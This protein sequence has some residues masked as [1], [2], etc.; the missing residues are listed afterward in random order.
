MAALTLPII[1][2]YCPVYLFKNIELWKKN[3][4]GLQSVPPALYSMELM[5]SSKLMSKISAHEAV[6]TKYLHQTHNT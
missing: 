4:L 1:T 6:I 5:N 3:H 2:M